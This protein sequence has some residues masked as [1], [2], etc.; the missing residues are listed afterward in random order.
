VGSPYLA[1]GLGQDDGGG[2]NWG[3]FA[4]SIA[5]SAASSAAQAGVS[6]IRNIGAP[7]PVTAIAPQVA[8]TPATA[9]GLP[10]TVP[11]YVWALGGLG[12]LM[13]LMLA[14]RR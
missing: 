4:T 7:K 13:I 12:L 8:A 11:T 9:L 10:T 14:M 5:S 1:R 2:F 6:L 3:N